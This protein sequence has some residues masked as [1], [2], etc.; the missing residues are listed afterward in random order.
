MNG[1]RPSVS[2][3]PGGFLLEALEPRKLLSHTSGLDHELFMPEGFSARNAAE[4]VEV[5]HA[6]ESGSTDWELW[7]HYERD[8]Q[9]DDI[10]RIAEGTI[11]AGQTQRV[12]IWG[13][14]KQT[15][16]PTGP[17][18]IRLVRPNEPYALVLRSNSDDVT[19]LLRHSDFGAQTAQYFIDR[20]ETEYTLA[21]IR[22]DEDASRD[23]I[24]LYNS[25][26][27]DATIRL[28]LDD[29]SGNIYRYST[30]VPSERRGGWDIRDMP[31]L[32]EGVYTARVAGDEAFVLGGT[33]YALGRGAATIELPAQT[34]AEAGVIL[35]AEFDTDDEDRDDTFL[36]IAN[37][38]ETDVQIQFRAFTG[39]G[40]AIEG[41]TSFVVNLSAGESTRVSLRAQGYTDADGDFSLAYRADAPITV[42]TV[43][44][45]RSALSFGQ[46]ETRASDGWFFDGGLV[47]EVQ[48]IE[49]DLFETEDVL[50]FNPTGLSVDVTVTFTFSD[51]TSIIE[52]MSLSSLAVGSIDGTLDYDTSMGTAFEGLFFSVSIDSTR[53]I[54]AMLELER[55]VAD[56]A[57]GAPV[58]TVAD[59]ADIAVF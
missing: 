41:P 43:I 20:S 45:R 23:F 58:G 50:L 6:S 15:F 52:N 17:S 55:K 2:H 56:A 53:P 54:V 12:A 27:R 40:G 36:F 22:R 32:P 10:V 7:A 28:K 18:I 30:V 21:G 37:P 29:G 39:D 44:E 31:G 16:R 4:V 9:D 19:A 46:P 8:G 11:D 57:H 25:S 14:V 42:N 24:V 33:R 1:R 49:S 34:L 3:G 48:G 38:G 47:G 35:D 5:A 51:G 59:L 26:E 13:L